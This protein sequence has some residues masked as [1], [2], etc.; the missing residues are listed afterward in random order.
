MDGIGNWT[1]KGEIAKDFDKHVRASVPLY[2]TIQSLILGMSYFFIRKDS[3]VVDLGHSTGETIL[4]LKRNI[5]KSF[6]IIGIDS[7]QK[8]IIEAKNKLSDITDVELINADIT[9]LKLPK[10]DLVISN[11]TMQFISIENRRKVI[12]N[13]Y[14]SLN[15]GGA[16]IMV[17]KVILPRGDYQNIYTQLYSDFKERQ[18]FNDKEIRDK[19]KSLRSVLVPLESNENKKILNSA[20]FKVEEFFRYL[21]FVGY[22]AIK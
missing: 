15:E 8:M 9:D 10:A 18:G 20:G 22:L 19:D 16:F 17:E 5:N 6:K 13:I 7:S 21:N 12:N 4:N 11:L 3:K 1:F 2:D 14:N